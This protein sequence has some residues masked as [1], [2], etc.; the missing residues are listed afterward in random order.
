MEMTLTVN[1]PRLTKTPN[2]IAAM[3]IRRPVAEVFA[4]FVD[5][6]ITSKFWFSRGSGK[7][8][9]GK[10]VQWDWERYKI[11]IQV[12]AKEIEPNRRILIEWPAYSGP[13][14]VEWIFTDR[15]DGT[16]F[17]EVTEEGFRGDADEVVKQ[18]IAS[19][20]GFALVLAGLKAL[21]EH[22]IR[23]NLVQDRFPESEGFDEYL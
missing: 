9:P 8:E 12:E 5:P 20:G 10:R 14:T 19:T 7:L 18:A 6:A 11:S 23:L 4:A 22:D 21:L 15:A 16:T 2:G 17:V 13:T 1:N 3:L